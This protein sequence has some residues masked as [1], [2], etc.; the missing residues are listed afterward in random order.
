MSFINQVG[1]ALTGVTG[2]GLFVGATS[3]SL[4]T[5]VLGTPSSGTLSSCTGYAQSAL[6]GLGTG[7]STALGINIGTAGSPVVNGGA[8]GTP[9]SGT[10][11]SCTGLPIAGTTGYGTG[12]ATAL[13]ANVT[14]SGGIALVTSPTFVTPVLGAATATSINFG[15][16]TLSTYTEGTFTPTLVSDGGGSTTYSSQIGS[17]TKIGNRVFFNVFISISNLPSAGNLSIAALPFTASNNSCVALVV[18]NLGVGA[19]TQ[20]MGVITSGTASIALYAY[21]SGSVS[22]LTVANS[23][24]SALFNISGFYT[25]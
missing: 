10:L 24:N 17:Y 18:N 15:G 5:P 3:P 22:Q 19:I 13:A 11:T 9:S 20:I 6:T 1:N 4:V 8:L 12:V 23:T 16:S 14:G 2:S 25:A 21:A 7:V